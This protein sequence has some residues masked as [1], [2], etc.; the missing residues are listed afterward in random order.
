MS[1]PNTLSYAI[2]A[3]HGDLA[4]KSIGGTA[5]SVEEMRDLATSLAQMEIEAIRLE[6]I[7]IHAR[8]S[9]LAEKSLAT[10]ATVEEALAAAEQA[11]LPRRRQTVD[12]EILEA[13]L[14]DDKVVIFP[15]PVRARAE[16]RPA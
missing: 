6:A 5:I 9:Q 8:S 14:R 15:G 12:L 10:V 13:M 2:A 3:L 1:A 4:R 16:G 7:E 11:G